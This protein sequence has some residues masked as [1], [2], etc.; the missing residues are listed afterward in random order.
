MSG[1]D[2]D[3]VVEQ[4]HRALDAIVRGDSGLQKKMFSGREDVSLANP[5]GPPVRGRSAVEQ[6]MDR[7][8]SQLREGEPTTF[9]RISEYIG[10]DLAYIVEI[11]RAQAK[12]GGSDELSRISLRVTTIFRLEDGH[13][14]VIHRHADPITSPRPIE[15]II[16]G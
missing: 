4:Y 9:E 5:I 8:V 7:A 6:A 12:V 1:S 11:E 13:W 2:L 10:T 15:S 3:L 14:K 16:Q